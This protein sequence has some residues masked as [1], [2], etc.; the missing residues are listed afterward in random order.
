MLFVCHIH[1]CLS[2]VGRM[3]KG[4]IQL[5][6]KVV[7]VQQDNELVSFVSCFHGWCNWS[8]REKTY[9]D[10]WQVRCDVRCSLG[11]VGESRLGKVTHCAP[12]LSDNDGGGGKNTLVIR[13]AQATE[14]VIRSRFRSATKSSSAKQRAAPPPPS[15]LSSPAASPPQAVVHQEPRAL[16]HRHAHLFRR[17]AGG[18]VLRLRLGLASS[19]EPPLPRRGLLQQESAE[20]RQQQQ[21]Q[22]QPEDHQRAEDFHLQEETLLQLRVSD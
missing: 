15:A 19:W 3:R 9:I 18:P 11:L 1:V 6:R 8:L 7:A 14:D 4:S 2:A 16:P 17:A 20:E 22:T 5:D 21:Q 13:R 12:K 10:P